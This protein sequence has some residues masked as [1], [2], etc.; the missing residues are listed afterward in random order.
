MTFGESIEETFEN[1]LEILVFRQ[2]KN[3][4]NRFIYMQFF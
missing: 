1:Y 2:R 3:I 4:E